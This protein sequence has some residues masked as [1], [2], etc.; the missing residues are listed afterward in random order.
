MWVARDK[1][2]TLT[3]FIDKPNQSIGGAWFV[4]G[5][6]ATNIIRLSIT[7]FSNLTFE[8]EPIEVDLARRLNIEIL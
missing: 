8:D 5:Y 6:Q 3:L 1:D 4:G 7:M 2:G